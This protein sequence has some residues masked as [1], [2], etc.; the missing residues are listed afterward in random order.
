[1]F[2][3][4]FVCVPLSGSNVTNPTKPVLNRTHNVY[5]MGVDGEEDPCGE[6]DPNATL[7]FISHHTLNLSRDLVPDSESQLLCL[8]IP[9]EQCSLLAQRFICLK[10]LVIFCDFEPTNGA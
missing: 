9:T 6:L 4:S 2:C 5:E 7:P 1:M 10:F 3:L 8:Q